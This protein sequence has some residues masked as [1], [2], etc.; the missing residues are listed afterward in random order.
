MRNGCHWYGYCK[1]YMTKEGYGYTIVG[2]AFPKNST[3]LPKIDKILLRLNDFGIMQHL[4][5]NGVINASECLKP[6]STNAV[7]LR[8]LEPKDFY[9]V[10]S[11]YIGGVFVA[12]MVLFVE[13]AV[14]ST[15]N[16]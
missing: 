11:L 3:L 9:G 6:P 12:M 10:F 13:L 1:M 2:L 16:I 5:R 8:P 7:S 14:V 15:G 4:H